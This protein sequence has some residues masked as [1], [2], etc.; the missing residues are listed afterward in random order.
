LLLALGLLSR[1][2]AFPNPKSPAPPRG[3]LVVA[4]AC[5]P[6][7]QDPW[8]RP[9]M[10]AVP[11]RPGPRWLRASRI[12]R[13]MRVSAF[14]PPPPPPCVAPLP[15]F[16]THR[17]PIGRARSAVEAGR[18]PPPA[19]RPHPPAPRR[20]AERAREGVRAHTH[21]RERV[22]VLRRRTGHVRP[23]GAAAGCTARAPREAPAADCKQRACGA[24]A[25][26]AVS[27]TRPP[28]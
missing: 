17:W 1:V 4:P 2:A 21:G 9:R 16:F 14:P 12:P 13:S 19:P 7:L 11:A 26:R 3:W 23:R 22:R 28:G 27:S 25:P 8:P 18:L 20:P 6:A 10:L 15:H 24:D 5:S